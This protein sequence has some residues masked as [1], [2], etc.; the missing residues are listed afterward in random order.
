MDA[1]LHPFFDELRD[2]KTR[3]PNGKA[4]PDLFKFTKDEILASNP[5]IME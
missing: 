3:L 4:L 2:I 5:Q 1:L